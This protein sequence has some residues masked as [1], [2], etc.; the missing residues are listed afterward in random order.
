LKSDGKSYRN[1]RITSLTYEKNNELRKKRKC[2]HIWLLAAHFCVLIKSS[3]K[4]E[5]EKN[6]KDESV[7]I[8][9]SN[10]VEVC[11]SDL[12]GTCGF[13]GAVFPRH[14]RVMLAM[15]TAAGCQHQ[16]EL[17]HQVCNNITHL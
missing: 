10:C 13:P 17:S 14:R 8:W 2:L 6:K 9:V 12:A 3:C 11:A 7:E 15:R 1:H 16:Y 5:V 4:L